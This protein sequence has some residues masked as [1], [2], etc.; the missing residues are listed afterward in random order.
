M[1]KE[2]EIKVIPKIQSNFKKNKLSVFSKNDKKIF[3]LIENSGFI[4][5]QKDLFI[6]IP[7]QDIS[8]KHCEIIYKEE[9][10]YLR[11]N[12]SVNGTY[13]FIATGTTLFI[14]NGTSV[15][16]G[17]TLFEFKDIIENKSI[18]VNIYIED[19]N[20]I[21]KTLKLDL[22]VKIN[23]VIGKRVDTDIKIEEDPALDEVHAVITVKKDINM[24]TMEVISNQGVW[25]KLDKNDRYPL[26]QKTEFRVGTSYQYGVSNAF[27][28]PFIIKPSKICCICEKEERNAVIFPCKHKV[29]GPKCLE[30]KRITACPECFGFVQQ[31]M[32]VFV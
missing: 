13:V 32:K 27:I 16:I 2:T 1:Q 23:H 24:I 12:N 3:D 31:F 28:K 21:D 18:L 10:Y 15:M 7:E 6:T 25:L 14:K 20:K 19:L 5:R 22:S 11:D 29:V 8:R 30:E 9:G 26:V 4:G 17:T